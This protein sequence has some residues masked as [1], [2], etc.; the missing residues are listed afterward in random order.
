MTGFE[1]GAALGFATAFRHMHR[2]PSTP[3]QVALYHARGPRHAAI[4]RAKSR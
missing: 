3:D 1:R 4:R 2:A